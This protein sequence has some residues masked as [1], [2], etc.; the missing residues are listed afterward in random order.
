[1][2]LHLR[3]VLPAPVER[4][5]QACTDPA[6][7]ESWFWPERFATKVETDPQADGAYRIAGT[8]MAVGGRYRTVD[9]PHRLVFTWQWDGDPDET[10]VTVELSPG[11]DGTALLLTHEGFT[12]ETDRDNHVTGW[13]DCLDRLAS[14]G[15]MAGWDE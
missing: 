4:V 7:L 6:A 11:G 5:W 2:E 12:T 8:D 3:R 15:T 14:R 1:M 10:L 9:P 13:S